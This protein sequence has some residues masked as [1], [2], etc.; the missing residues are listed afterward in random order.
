[1]SAT[2]TLLVRAEGQDLPAY[3]L[4]VASINTIFADIAVAL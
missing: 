1:M 4:L 2:R 3:A